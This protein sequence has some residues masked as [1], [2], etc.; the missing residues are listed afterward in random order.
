MVEE[1]YSTWVKDVAWEFQF[2]GNWVNIVFEVAIWG[3]RSSYWFIVKEC[4]LVIFGFVE[5]GDIGSECS[6]GCIGFFIWGS[7]GVIQI[8]VFE[9][10]FEHYI[11]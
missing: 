6:Y 3:K 10:M 8:Q 11:S 2:I 4:E 1:E 7:I 9:S 5:D